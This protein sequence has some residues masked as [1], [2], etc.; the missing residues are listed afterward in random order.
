MK[1]SF[2]LLL[3]CPLLLHA[4][5]EIFYEISF[6]NA[7]HHEAELKVKYSKLEADTLNIIMSLTS[8]GRYAVHNFAK[9]IYNLKA[10]DGFGTDLKMLHNYPNQ[11]NI[12]G[13]EGTAEISYTLFAAYADGT[14]SEI[15]T[16]HAHLNIPSA[17]IWAKGLEK[18]PIKI[19]FNVPDNWNAATQLFPTIDW[20]IYTAP[21]LQYFMDSPVELSEFSERSWDIESN[22]EEYTMKLAIHHQ[23]DDEIVDAY[24]EMIKAVVIEQKALFGELPEFDNKVYTFIADYLPYVHED[25]MEH[26]NSAVLTNNFQIN[27]AVT[28]LIGTVSHEFFHAWNGERIRP[29]SIEPFDFE[30]P[31]VCNELWFA[32][33]VT[34]YYEELILC[35][36]GIINIDKFADGLSPSLSNVLNSPGKKYYGPAEMSGFASFVDGTRYGDYQNIS[37]TYIS[38]YS[39]GAAIALAL[40]LTLRREYKGITLD[41][42]MKKMWGKYGRKEKPYDNEEIKATLA[43][44]TNDA[45]FAE[46]FFSQF[47]YGKDLPDFEDLLSAAGL[48]I[49]KKNPGKSYLGN[50]IIRI[51]NNKAFLIESVV[52]N[53][54]LYQTG[55]DLGDA[56]IRIDNVNITDMKSID[57]V[58]S[59]HKPGQTVLIRFEKQGISQFKEIVFEEDPAI[60][61][62]TFE[63][64]NGLMSEK[65]RSFRKQWLSS[66]DQ[67]K[68]PLLY[69]YCSI[70]GRRYPFTYQYCSTDGGELL[71]TPKKE[72]NS[73]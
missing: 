59:S 11:W 34:D 20:N 63:K 12:Y 27:A 73:K 10:T 45:A 60:E 43:E 72:E 15:N 69:K 57:S 53:S 31:V 47:I 42:L 70:C 2:F 36:V 8:P 29:K 19:K 1:Y 39:Y 18:L 71:L 41:N 25:G 21:N 61:I 16:S 6:D 33:G 26:R 17:F 64:V 30:K 48:T 51:R 52:K 46:K 9:N 44:I 22:D 37:N 28:K 68:L 32:E 5:T 62:V 7:V 55:I 14:Y 35:R 56:I 38:Y 49:T 13:I 66:L 65:I 4:Q 40:D 54:P 50:I 58:L 67:E 3:F 23:G 24:V